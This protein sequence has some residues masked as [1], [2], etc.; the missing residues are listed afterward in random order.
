MKNTWHEDVREE[1]MIEKKMIVKSYIDAHPDSTLIKRYFEEFKNSY[2][3]NTNAIEGNPVTE[4]DTAYIIQ[5]KN[6]LENYSAKDNMEI[7]GSSNAWDYVLTLPE[8]VEETVLNIHKEILFFD[9]SH[10]GVYRRIPVH[11]G[12]KQMPAPENISVSMENVFRMQTDKDLFET[13]AQMHLY[14]ENIHPFIDGNGRTGRMLMNL[15][16]MQQGYLPINIKQNDAGKYY[17]CFRQ[18]DIAPEKG[19]QELFNLI[20][21]YEDEELTKIIDW[22]KQDN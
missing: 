17:R 5:S 4:Y 22:I 1:S 7:L 12:D 16:L 21:K 14:F 19:V 2:I 13:V 15:Q 8:I 6:F 3:F 11:I 18:Y 10:A 9:V 20:T